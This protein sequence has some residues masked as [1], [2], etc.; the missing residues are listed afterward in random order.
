MKKT[1]LIFF[2]I[3][4]ALGQ[5]LAFSGSTSTVSVSVSSNKSTDAAISLSEEAALAI[6]AHNLLTIKADAQLIDSVNRP[7]FSLFIN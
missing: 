5:L 7:T 3:L 1:L 2:I 4:S 6:A